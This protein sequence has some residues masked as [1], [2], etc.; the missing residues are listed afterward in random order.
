MTNKLL[1]RLGTDC[2]DNFKSRN[3]NITAADDA[4]DV[5]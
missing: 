4:R 2:Q 1:T 5:V 3:T